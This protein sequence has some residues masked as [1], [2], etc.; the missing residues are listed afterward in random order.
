MPCPLKSGQGVLRLFQFRAE[1]EG[2]RQV[3]NFLFQEQG[4][5]IFPFQPFKGQ[6]FKFVG[7]VPFQQGKLFAFGQQVRVGNVHQEVQA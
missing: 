2:F 5:E 3:E 1:G 4:I 6:P 7:V